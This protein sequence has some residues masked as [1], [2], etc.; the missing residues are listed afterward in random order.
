MDQLA[1]IRDTGSD[2][3]NPVVIGFVVDN[4]IKPMMIGRSSNVPFILIMLGVLGAAA[5]FGFLGIFIGP[6]LLAVA[7]AVL[8]EWTAES[9]LKAEEELEEEASLARGA[10]PL[11]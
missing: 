10:Q 3:R 1:G 7:H 2:Y 9:A 4:V 11:P 8:Q 5:A 6:T